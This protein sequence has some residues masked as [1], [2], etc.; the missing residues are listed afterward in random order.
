MRIFIKLLFFTIIFGSINT[1]AQTKKE[2][3][4]ILRSNTGSHLLWDGI[5]VNIWGFA[6]NLSS[7]PTLPGKTLTVN[8]GDTVII[9]A[10][11]VSQ[12]HHHTIHL[13]GLDVDTQN[14]GDPMTS[15]SLGHMEEAYYSF[16]ASHAGTY[17]YHCHVGD[18]V[19][20]QM[21]MYGLLIVKAKDGK[22]QAWTDGPEFHKEYAWL[23]SEIDKSWHDNVPEHDEHSEIIHLPPYRPNYFLINGKSQDQLNDSLTSVSGSVG[24]KIYLRLAN[25]GFLHNRVRFPEYL[26]AEIIDSDGRPLPVRELSDVV[27]LSPGERY[28]VLLN[29]EMEIEGFIEV[30]YIDMNT[31]EIKGIERV[32]TVIKDFLS[33][34][35][36]SQRI[37]PI[38]FPNPTS[39]YLNIY[40]PQGAQREVCSIEIYAATGKKIKELKAVSTSEIQLDV[41]E[42]LP[43]I[44]FLKISDSKK[45]VSKKFIKVTE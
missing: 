29:A 2:F 39:K 21:G 22:S 26:N 3:T 13:H 24:E 44:Y 38:L 11:N 27:N 25:I 10:R 36:L 5:T 19:H 34:K 32:P 16:V 28:G 45:S 40:Y 17:I 35:E 33:T 4:V 1:H 42:L 14:D 30:E 18:V 23:M 9:K 12:N 41:S 15:F 8:E 7:A 37:D 6:S 31:G 20:V 43:G